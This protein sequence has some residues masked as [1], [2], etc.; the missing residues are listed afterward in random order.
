MT[1]LFRKT[2]KYSIKLSVRSKN[3]EQNSTKEKRK[4]YNSCKNSN[5]L[6]R[7]AINLPQPFPR[8]KAKSP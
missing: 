8:K 4:I 3:K 5:S 2:K 1:N 6:L 7:K